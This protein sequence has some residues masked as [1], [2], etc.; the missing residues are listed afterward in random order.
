MVDIQSKE[1]IDK[2]SDELKVQP[3]LQIPRELAKQIQLTYDVGARRIIDIARG[4][5][6]TTSGDLNIFVTPTDK[7]FFLVSCS[8][9]YIKDAA[10]DDATGIAARILAT[11]DGVGRDLLGL[12]GI[13]LTASNDSIT[14]FFPAAIKL[15]RGTAIS[16]TG[17]SFTLGVKVRF[18][19]MKGFTADPQ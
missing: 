10:C 6:R 16:I 7:D 15:S 2:I 13:T 8:I 17:G 11:I 9:G 19:T 14:S 3:A 4:G 1:V 5:V 18:G 12:P